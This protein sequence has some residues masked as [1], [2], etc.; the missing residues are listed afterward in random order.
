MASL[1]IVQDGDRVVLVHE[2]RAI[3]LPHEAAVAVGQQLLAAGR[4]AEKIA[5]AERVVADQALVLRLG[6]PFGL[7]SD[8][9]LQ[10]EAMQ[11]AQYDR[12]LRRYLP[13][14]IRSRGVVGTPVLIRHAPKG[15]ANGEA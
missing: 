15:A 10:A 1:R 12:D 9:V 14:G 8:P 7:T 5:K 6:L 11:V 3:E 13:G 2:G 4:R